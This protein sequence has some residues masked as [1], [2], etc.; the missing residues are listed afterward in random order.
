MSRRSALSP[1][2][3]CRTRRCSA[4]A[5]RRTNFGAASRADAALAPRFAKPIIA[6]PPSRDRAMKDNQDSIPATIL[7]LVVGL[8]V[9]LLFGAV[10]YTGGVRPIADMVGLGW[11]AS[12]MVEVPAKVVGVQLERINFAESGAPTAR[13]KL[14]AQYQ[15][16]WRGVRYEGS[17][18]SLQPRPNTFTGVE[19]D[20]VW[21]DK[22]DQARKT[23][24]TVP[25]WISPTGAH[26]AV[27]DKE[28]RYKGFWGAVAALTF[29]IVPLAF[30]GFI[31]FFVW[32]RR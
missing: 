19:W 26:G 18:V 21:F 16:E 13:K 8:L 2:R 23:G 9:S 29:G 25:A 22:L 11:R 1:E 6:R 32:L 5:S 28:V 24:A 14:H 12:S 15:Y 4:T 3:C 31:V 27:L 20:E 10:A 7:Q 30:V 17:Q